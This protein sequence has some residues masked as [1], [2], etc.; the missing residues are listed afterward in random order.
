MLGQYLKAAKNIFL[1]SLCF[2]CERKTNDKYLCAGC[3]DKIEFIYPPLCRLCSQPIVE[4]KGGLCQNCLE[5]DTPYEKLICIT[6]YKEPMV[7]LI[8]L[9]KYK[10]YACLAEVFS[11][12]M[13]E[14]LLKI[15][16][17][18]SPFDIITA[19]PM[20]PAKLRNRGYNQSAMLALLLA[21]YF[22]ITF[23]NDIIYESEQRPSQS[24]LNAAKRQKNIEG[25]FC[26][27]EN[28][29][30]AKIILIDDILTTGSTV[31]ACAYALKEKGAMVTAIAL[32]K[33]Q[34][35]TE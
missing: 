30:G 29:S 16:F 5:K 27:K 15:G 22:K 10:D 9:F 31:K 21:N 35:R 2:N 14:H 20:H 25:V 17:S 6:R 33:T 28:M 24:K 26:V 12:F 8:H 11:Q 7:N 1:P 34:G 19:V 3:K 18:F 23:K 13:I 4:D 32:A